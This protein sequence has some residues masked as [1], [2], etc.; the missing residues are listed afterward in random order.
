MA[1]GDLP[2]W[3]FAAFAALAGFGLAS[4]QWV[5][6]RPQRVSG[7]LSLLGVLVSAFVLLAFFVPRL[8]GVAAALV[9]LATIALFK[10]M[11]FFERRT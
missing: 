5:W 1:I 7:S 8:S 6:R 3:I 10:L 4:W 2:A 9:F 11:S